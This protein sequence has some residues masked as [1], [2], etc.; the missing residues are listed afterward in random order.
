MRN[1]IDLMEAFQASITPTYGKVKN[2]VDIFRNPSSKEWREIGGNDNG[3]RGYLVGDDLLVWDTGKTLHF[4]VREQL[5]L[6]DKAIPVYI[7]GMLRQRV[8]VV[9]S[10]ASKN[11]PWFHNPEVSE[12][13]RENAFMQTNFKGISVGYFDE[14]IVGDWENLHDD[15]D[16]D[17]QESAVIRDGA[18][19][20]RKNLTEKALTSMLMSSTDKRLRGLVVGEDNFYW[21]AFKSTHYDA[22]HVM[23]VP[24]DNGD[25]FW[26]ILEDDEIRVG[27]TEHFEYGLVLNN[28]YRRLMQSPTLLFD[29]GDIGYVTGDEIL[30]ALPKQ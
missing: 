20:I 5:K 12:A 7:Y 26:V 30:K 23:G 1:F 17:L 22:A 13:I 8:E 3:V 10:D 28:A 27:W 29:G 4:E 6:N 15:D 21:D 24:Y 16:D 18:L 19:V 2:P 14:D 11:T 9:V 25:R